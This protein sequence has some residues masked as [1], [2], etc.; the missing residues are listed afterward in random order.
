M[1]VRGSETISQPQHRGGVRVCPCARIAAETIFFVDL[2][3]FFVPIVL[4][5]MRVMSGWVLGGCERG[6]RERAEEGRERGLKRAGGGLTAA[7]GGK[8]KH[9]NN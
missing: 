2:G 5:V 3:D 6:L 4:F 8:H 1:T 9:I 7:V